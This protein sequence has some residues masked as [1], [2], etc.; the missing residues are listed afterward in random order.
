MDRVLEPE[1][2]DDEAQSIAYARAD[3]ST[4]NQMFVDRLIGDLPMDR[5]RILDLGCGPGDVDIRL[6]RSTPGT[7]ITAVDGSKPMIALAK[8]A[9]KASGLETRITVVHGRLPGLPLEAHGFD[10][11]LSKDL[12]H[13]LPDPSVLWNEVSRLGRH[14][15]AVYVMDLI[16][17]DTSQTA[18]HIV[19]TVAANEDPILRQDFF[20]SLC[21]AFTVEEVRALLH[22]AG[23]A[24]AV[25]RIGERHLLAHGLLG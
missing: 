4:S 9:V 10:A 25:E 2:M 11:I 20:N 12:L 1:L 23:L 22:E 7:T 5:R 6:A 13:H 8:Q 16:R 15:A 21:A 3:F 14:G 19:D 17:P 18:Q 24:L